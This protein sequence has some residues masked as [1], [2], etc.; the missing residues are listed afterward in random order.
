MFNIRR[1]LELIEDR[2]SARTD[3]LAA[4]E[5]IEVARK[6]VG[7]AAE[8]GDQIRLKLSGALESVGIQSDSG[9]SLETIMAV[10][11][12]FLDR[13][14]KVD[15]ERAEA[16][17]TVSAKEEDLAARRRAVDVAERH[18]EEWLAGVAEVLKG[19]WLENGLSAPA[20]G[21]V[22]AQLA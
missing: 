21:N 9:E 17:R 4:W 11:E 13:Q 5:E 6:K 3:S 20:V 10:T 7:R 14:L 18:E 8:E 19:T 2:A 15:A 16:L 1:S 12:L 22:L